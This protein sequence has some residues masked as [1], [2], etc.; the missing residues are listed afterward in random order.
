MWPPSPRPPSRLLLARELQ[1]AG[2][3]RLLLAPARRHQRVDEHNVGLT[4]VGAEDAALVGQA[5]V[6][7]REVAQA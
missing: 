7:V 3:T 2:V 4:D 5:L 6:V 1:H